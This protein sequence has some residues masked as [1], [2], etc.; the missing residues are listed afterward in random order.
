MIVVSIETKG[1]KGSSVVKGATG[2]IVKAVVLMLKDGLID[3]VL[4]HIDW[5]IAVML[6][7]MVVAVFELMVTIAMRIVVGMSSVAVSVMGFIAMLVGITISLMVGLNSI[8][9]DVLV[10]MLIGLLD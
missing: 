8:F 2:I 5:H 6:R 3:V 9:R 1:S 4:R 7:L 10:T